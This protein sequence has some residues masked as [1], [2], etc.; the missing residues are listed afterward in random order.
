MKTLACPRDKIIYDEVRGE[1]ICTDTGEVL[2]DHVIDQGPEWRIFSPEDKLSKSRIGSPLTNIVHDKGLITYIG[3]GSR[4]FS[5]YQR[6]KARKLKEINRK[7][8]VSPRDRKLVNM[9]S[10]LNNVTGRLGLPARVRETAAV[11]LRKLYE[12]HTIRK[13][14]LP[15]Y[16]AATIYI[17]CRVNHISSRTKEEIM[18][19]LDVGPREFWNAYRKIRDKVLKSPLKPSRPTDYVAKIAGKLGLPAPVTTLAYKLSALM[20]RHGLTDGKGPLGVAA[21][22]VY[23]AAVV[24]DSKKTQREVA[25]AADVTEVTVRNR[26]KD[27]VDNFLIEVSI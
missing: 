22:S 10:E 27:I 1:Y 21:A 16:L 14:Q 9:L 11:I 4:K 23:V 19:I 3:K 17:A 12:K 7:L 26:Y 25:D 6:R 24:L 20:V 13:P 18:E 5:D 2:E 15:S 8:R